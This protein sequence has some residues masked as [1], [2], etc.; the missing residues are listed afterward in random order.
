MQ[1]K[2]QVGFQAF[3]SDGGEEFGAVRAVAPHELT[4]YVENAGDFT[5]PISAVEA[6]HSEKVVLDCAKLDKRLRRAIG[7]AH[8]K[9][10]PHA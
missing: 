3:T 2:I 8:D 7:H 5:V 4:I 10:E 9:E 1:E 6:V